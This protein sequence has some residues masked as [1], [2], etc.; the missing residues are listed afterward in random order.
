MQVVWNRYTTADISRDFYE[1]TADH[2]L[3]IKAEICLLDHYLAEMLRVYPGLGGTWAEKYAAGAC[4]NGG[5]KN[6]LY[7][8]RNFGIEWL[9][10]Q[11]RMADLARKGTLSAKERGELEWLRKFRNHETFIYLNK[12]HAIERLQAKRPEFHAPPEPP[13]EVAS[14]VAKGDTERVW[15]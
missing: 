6:V 3:A 10:P 4:Y 9:H 13:R 1:A 2:L 11:R 5:P 15:Q 14:P 7:G 8:L 12:I